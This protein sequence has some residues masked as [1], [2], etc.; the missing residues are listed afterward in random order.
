MNTA[1]R[2]VYTLL[3]LFYRLVVRS[4]LFFDYA[5][6]CCRLRCGLL[7]W[8]RCCLPATDNGSAAAPFPVHLVAD[9]VAGYCCAT[10]LR[11][12]PCWVV[13]VLRARDATAVT[14]A[15]WL[16]FIFLILL[17]F[18]RRCTGFAPSAFVRCS[19]V[20]GFCSVLRLVLRSFGYL[21][22][23][24]PRFRLRCV[25]TALRHACLYTVSAV[26]GAAG[27]LPCHLL[28]YA[29][30]SGLRL[31]RYCCAAFGT[32]FCF[33]PAVSLPTVWCGHLPPHACLPSA[34]AVRSAFVRC[35][36]LRRRVSAFYVAGYNALPP[37]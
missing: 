22:H 35:S 14:A 33:L 4:G 17:D 23:G 27:S 10:R 6:R 1:C 34:S 21:H 3:R 31:L 2:L 36:P 20:S 7:R 5:V 32:T 9:L 18:R 25:C 28:R 24:L 12:V 30:R 13:A 29:E 11:R 15:H 16:F 8:V 37:R 19:A 26:A